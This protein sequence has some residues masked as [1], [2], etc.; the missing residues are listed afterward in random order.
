ML[1]LRLGL[2]LL[3]SASYL[4]GSSGLA[5]FQARGG[6]GDGEGLD[7]GQ[8][9]AID[10]DRVLLRVC[11]ISLLAGTWSFFVLLWLCGLC[12]SK[13]CL[14]LALALAFAFTGTTSHT[15]TSRDALP[16]LLLPVGRRQVAANS[17]P[18]LAANLLLIF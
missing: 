6:T 9:A 2:C 11:K 16:R 13:S 14:T 12:P 7:G 1:R 3:P 5:R 18:S 8:D 4:A 17:P 10:Y 15:L